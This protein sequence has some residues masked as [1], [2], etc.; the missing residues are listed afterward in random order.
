MTLRVVLD[1]NCLVSA[2]LLSRDNFVWLRLAWQTGQI[3]PVFCKETANELIRVL[4]YPKFKLTAAEQQM[5]LSEILPYAEAFQVFAVAEDMP[6]CR[7]A[8]DQI[9]ISLA[10]T[11]HADVLVTGDDDLLSM[12]PEISLI[13]M[14]TVRAFRE[15]FK[16]PE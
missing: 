13:K 3:I 10:V 4:N 5:L 14:M 6:V 1:T 9:F 2:L 11:S 16:E 12:Q 15:M 8:D 7:D